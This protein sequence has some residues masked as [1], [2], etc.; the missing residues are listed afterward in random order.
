MR[1]ETSSSVEQSKQISKRNSSQNSSF[2]SKH[3]DGSKVPFEENASSDNF[4]FLT[5]ISNVTNE[6]MTAEITFNAKEKSRTPCQNQDMSKGEINHTDNKNCIEYIYEAFDDDDH[7]IRDIC[8]IS[9][10]NHSEKL[11]CGNY[12][13]ISLCDN[14]TQLNYANCD[15]LD[16]TNPDNHYDHTNT[17]EDQ[18]ASS[19][20]NP[21]DEPRQ[22]ET[23]AT[24]DT[25]LFEF[26]I[27]SGKKSVAFLFKYVRVFS[28]LYHK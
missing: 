3:D 4:S 15:Q 7:C 21:R 12:V 26:K 18:L 19:K 25:K 20:E 13:E 28:S 1:R 8:E 24:A 5:T 9:S 10:Q 11:N 27:V 17:P 2:V 16:S 23:N 6:P 22:I 14:K